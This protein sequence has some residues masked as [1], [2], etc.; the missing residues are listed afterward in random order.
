MS[1]DNGGGAGGPPRNLSNATAKKGPLRFSNNVT[2]KEYFIENLNDL[3]ER[4]PNEFIGY[5]VLGHYMNL[6]PNRMLPTPP[7][8]KK[9]ARVIRDAR[10]MHAFHGVPPNTINRMMAKYKT[11]VSKSIHLQGLIRRIEETL[12]EVIEDRDQLMDILFTNPGIVTKAERR[13]LSA[14]FAPHNMNTEKNTEA[15]NASM[16]RILRTLRASNNSRA[17]AHEFAQRHAQINVNRAGNNVNR[18]MRSRFANTIRGMNI[19]SNRRRYFTRKQKKYFGKKKGGGIRV[20]HSALKA[21]GAPRRTDNPLSISNAVTVETYRKPRVS[22][23]YHPIDPRLYAPNVNQAILNYHTSI[24]DPSN[25]NSPGELFSAVGQS[26]MT[27]TKGEGPMTR[28]YRR[29]LLHAGI[30]GPAME[31]QMGLFKQGF[32]QDAKMMGN[33]RDV[34]ERTGRTAVG[35]NNIDPVAVAIAN[36]NVVDRNLIDRLLEADNEDV[37][38]I[39]AKLSA[40]KFGELVDHVFA[41]LYGQIIV[42]PRN[43]DETIRQKFMLLIQ[44]LEPVLRNAVIQRFNKIHGWPA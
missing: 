42:T 8:T 9:E 33:I 29:N 6:P 35:H 44:N 26:P 40:T 3:D 10:L 39:K 43:T 23:L 2:R 17:Y 41:N 16:A 37:N 7:R 25:P 34:Q 1:S 19:S 22:N 5:N 20:L 24:R 13:M 21:P 31:H 14:A 15:K 27:G 30:T 12:G 38:F 36:N 28:A 32:S 11:N 4:G 18:Y